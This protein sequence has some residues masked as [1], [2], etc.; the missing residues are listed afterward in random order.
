MGLKELI[1]GKGQPAKVSE[2]LTQEKIEALRKSTKLK[3]DYAEAIDAD[4]RVE[5]KLFN[6]KQ[7]QAQAVKGMLEQ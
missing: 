1:F 3:E 2:S 4:A 7:A 5:Q 6:A